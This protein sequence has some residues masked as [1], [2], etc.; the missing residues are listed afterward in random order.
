MGAE[1]RPGAG[2]RAVVFLDALFADIRLDLASDLLAE[3]DAAV[4][5]VFRVI[6]HQEAA[7]FRMVPQVEFD[8]DPADGEGPRR[9]VDV[10]RPQF[11]EFT[12]AEAGFDLHFHEQFY[13]RA[14]Q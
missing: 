12:P 8:D 6:L 9:E 1:V 3:A 13:A 5:P 4:L 11:G 10:L 7:A 2:R 14:G